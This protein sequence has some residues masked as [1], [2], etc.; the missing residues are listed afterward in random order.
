M[1]ANFNP[2]HVSDQGDETHPQ[3][4]MASYSGHM[5]KLHSHPHTSYMHLSI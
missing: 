2:K 4:I 5:P 1:L 3:K